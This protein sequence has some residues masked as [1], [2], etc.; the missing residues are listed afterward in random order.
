M[1]VHHSQ[2]NNFSVEE[3]SGDKLV[4]VSIVFIVLNTVIVSLRCYARS[5]TNAPYGWD[6]YL[7]FASFI[8]NVGLSVVSIRTAASTPFCME[9]IYLIRR[10]NQAI[11]L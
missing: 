1:L 8:S 7:V 3:Y 11:E 2:R 6:D 9:S 5:I 10:T 4:T